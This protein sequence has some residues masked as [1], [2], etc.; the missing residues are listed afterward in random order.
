MKRAAPAKK[1][2]W[3]KSPQISVKKVFSRSLEK[4]GGRGRAEVGEIYLWVC[5]GKGS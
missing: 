2:L 1:G 5:R 3:E 4:K